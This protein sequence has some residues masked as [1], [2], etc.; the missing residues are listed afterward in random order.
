M[1]SW[2]LRATCLVALSAC[3][4]EK[5]AFVDE[6]AGTPGEGGAGP[7][8]VTPT[9]C[10]ADDD[11][12]NLAATTV[13]DA[14]SGYCVECLPD[15]E[16]ALDRCPA[17]L[18]CDVGGRCAIGCDADADCGAL[19]C[20]RD[21]HVCTG[22]QSDLDCS[23]GTRCENA[24]CIRGCATNDSC[25]TS[26]LCCTGECKNPLTDSGHCGACAAACEGASECLNG[27]CGSPRCEPG[28]AECDGDT[29]TICEAD[30]SNDPTNCGKC[31]VT[32]ASEFCSG[33]TCTSVDCPSGFADCNQ[34]EA[35][36]CE[37]DLTTVTDC[38]SCE[39]RC[40]DVHGEPSCTS[41]GCRIAC[42]DG[43]DDC[44]EDVETGCE[45]RLATDAAHCGSCGN[46]CTNEN[47]GTRCVE[48]ECS[49]RCDGGFGDCDGDPANGCE[50]DLTTSLANCGACGE[51]CAPPHADG[52]CEE[53]VC[54]ARCDTG[55][56]DCNGDVVDGCES[57]LGDPDTCGSCTN[58]C[59]ANGGTASCGKGGTCDIVCD[60]DRADCANGLEDGCETNSAVSTLHCGVCDR[61]CPTT[62]GTPACRAGVCGFSTC[63]DP[64]RECAPDD[65]VACETNV[66]T[67]L[68]HCGACGNPCYFP[69][70]SAACRAGVC[71]LTGCSAGYADCSNA[72]GCETLLGTPEHCRN[73]DET[74]TN[75][76]GTNACRDSGCE[77]TCATGYADCDGDPN[78]GCETPLYTL[79]DCRACNDACSF[80]NATAS[81]TTGTCTLIGCVS[82]FGDCTAAA[83]CETALGSDVNCAACG[84]RCLNDPGT[85][86]CQASGSSF[87]CAPT[88]TTGY[89]NCDANPDNGCEATLASTTDCGVCGRACTGAT[90]YCRNGA[91]TATPPG[92][93]AGGGFA[94]CDDFEDNNASDWTTT[95]GSWSITSDPSFVYVGGAG[96]YRSTKGSTSWTNQ[97]VQSRMKILHFDAGSSSYRAG[98]MARFGES[99]NY[100]TFQVDGA[101]DL[102]LLRGTSTVSGNG[103][104]GIVAAS[105]ATGTWYTLKLQVSGGTN[106]ARLVTSYSVNGTTFTPVHDCTIT[107]GTLDGGSAGVITVGTSTNAEFDDFA[108]TTP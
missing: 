27:L 101:G 11:C 6:D 103:S 31:R 8:V 29:A 18:F 10:D 30:V 56:D 90:P 74:C 1:V 16:A 5:Y 66:T 72:L 97:T 52:V 76:H 100:Y 60:D 86:R 19:L 104:C 2:L 57:D 94:L 42:D 50:T 79:T 25:P 48:G 37:T 69:N 13:C 4:V 23:A 81:C 105:L 64:Y 45:T 17:G 46:E 63:V 14:E 61:A 106:A 75:A 43:Y 68:A 59:G 89:G 84:N 33:G 95:G 28:T 9:V 67:D 93:C 62:M 36:R 98:I 39:T 82:G 58:H 55:F 92:L 91:C 71:A 108:V 87:D 24:T 47:G 54:T 3:A 65:G 21:E 83:G 44:D 22:C 53:G 73:C 35:D 15:R 107:S 80:T 88:C 32:C 49:P 70:G 26:W 7:G 34:E 99:T 41:R 96:S 78:N 77:P 38:G 102:R 51:R 40:S 12:A 85:N 20:D